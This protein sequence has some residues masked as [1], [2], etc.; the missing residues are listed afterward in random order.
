MPGRLIIASIN[1]LA[2]CLLRRTVTRRFGRSTSLLFTLITVTQF[3]VPFWMGRTLP[4]MLALPFGE[5]YIPVMDRTP[6]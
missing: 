6:R 3:H 2:I 1:A 5:I 4:N